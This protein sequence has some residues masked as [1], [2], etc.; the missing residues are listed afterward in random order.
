MYVV[1][2]R[3]YLSTDCSTYTC[4][5]IY[6]YTYMHLYLIFINYD[7]YNK[8]QVRVFRLVTTSIVEERILARATDKRNLNGLVV[9]A[10]K[11]TN[12]D[13]SESNKAMVESMLNEW[14]AGGG[15]VGAEVVEGAEEG[16]VEEEV[17]AEVPDDDQ[18]NEMM[19]THDNEMVIYEA[20]DRERRIMKEKQLAELNK[21]LPK[22]SIPLTMP[23]ALMGALEKPSWYTYKYCCIDFH[24]NIQTDEYIK[25]SMYIYIYICIYMYINIH[26]CI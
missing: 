5:Y 16:E 1:E 9:E 19:S 15:G 3:I 8:Y 10:G 13:E 24:I 22:G 20:M 6:S 26:I 2:E 14:S 23:S 21:K 12:K 11:F 25:K 17:E 4:V 7:D 18:I